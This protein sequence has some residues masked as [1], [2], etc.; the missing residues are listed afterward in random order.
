MIESG[1]MPARARGKF[2]SGS[3]TS[4]LRIRVSAVP[5]SAHQ[6]TYPVGPAATKRQPG[7]PTGRSRLPLRRPR[8]F[9]PGVPELQPQQLPPPSRTR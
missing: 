2:T 8:H 3:R 5:W 6:M 9:A 7:M 1:A 4:K